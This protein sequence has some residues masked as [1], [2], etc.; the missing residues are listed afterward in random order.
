MRG[1]LI[2]TFLADIAPI[3][4][5]AMTASPGFDPDFHEPN[6]HDANA[7]GLDDKP[8]HTADVLSLPCQVEPGG[9]EELNMKPAGND[10][11]IRVGLVFHMRDVSKLPLPIRVGDTLVG[12]RNRAGELMLDFSGDPLFATHVQPRG[13]GLFRRSPS[14]NLLLVE[15]RSRVRAPRRVK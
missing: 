2:F 3:D 11:D 13:F 7:D 12:L 6:P 5:E 8:R 1:S 4:S 9:F 14:M 10:P 15:F